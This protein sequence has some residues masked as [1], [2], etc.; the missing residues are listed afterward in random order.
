M[1]IVREKLE[2]YLVGEGY[3][4]DLVDANR[5]IKKG[6]SAHKL[7]YSLAR[8]AAN[9]LLNAKIPGTIFSSSKELHE[10]QEI[11]ESVKPI[12]EAVFHK[13]KNGFVY[14][15]IIA[16]ADSLSREQMQELVSTCDDSALKSR[17]FALHQ[18]FVQSG[19]VIVD[20]YLLFSDSKVA[21]SFCKSDL[22]KC[23]VSHR[24]KK[25][26]INAIAIDI[27]TQEVSGTDRPLGLGGL[28]KKVRKAIL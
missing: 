15:A 9:H 25:A 13:F 28:E 12:T 22:K 4:I 16:D 26:H 27:N 2:D 3:Y 23:K 8:F 7:V 6:I 18:N 1:P 17:K 10:F 21:K 20:I 24:F 11:W 19:W 14:T 5:D